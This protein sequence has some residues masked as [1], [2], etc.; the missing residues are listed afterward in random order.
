MLLF[1]DGIFG[2]TWRWIEWNS[3]GTV[4]WNYKELSGVDWNSIGIDSSG[5]ERDWE[6]E[7]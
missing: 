4:K 2:K 7:S 6:N 5:I 3:V 1:T